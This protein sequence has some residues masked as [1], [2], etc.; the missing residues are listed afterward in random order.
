MP[1]IWSMVLHKQLGTNLDEP[2]AGDVA[3]TLQAVSP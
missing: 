3:L 2:F 1:I